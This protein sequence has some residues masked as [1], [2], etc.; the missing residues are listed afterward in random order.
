VSQNFGLNTN[1]IFLCQTS[2]DLISRPWTTAEEWYLTLLQNIHNGSGDHLSSYLMVPVG[3]FPGC[4][5]AGREADNSPPTSVEVKNVWS[6]ICTPLNLY[7]SIACM[8]KTYLYPYLKKER[9]QIWILLR[10][11]FV[12]M[13]SPTWLHTDGQRCGHHSWSEGVDVESGHDRDYSDDCS[14]SFLSSI[15]HKLGQRLKLATIALLRIF[16]I[17]HAQSSFDSMLYNL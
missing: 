14:L 2:N 13:Y 7:V 9:Q 17:R 1:G 4:K 6:Y 11:L 16:P 10:A 15:Y 12:N 8:L 3:S 5:A